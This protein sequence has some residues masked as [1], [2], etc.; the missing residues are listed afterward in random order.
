MP[1]ANLRL[2]AKWTANAGTAY[3]AKHYQENIAAGTYTLAATQASSGTSGTTVTPPLNTYT[4]FTAPATQT[5]TIKGDGSTVLNY[6]YTRNSYQRTFHP[7]NGQSDTVNT[8][9]YGALIILPTVT[10]AGYT[11]GGWYDNGAFTGTPYTATSTMPAASLELYAKWTANAGTAYTVKH[12]RE[13]LA[14]TL[15]SLFETETLYGTSGSPVAP[16][17]RTYEGFAAPAPQ[18]V[19]INGDGST[20][21]RYEYQRMGYDLICHPENGQPGT[22]TDTIRY[23]ATLVLPPVAYVGFTFEGWF[24]NANYTGQPYVP[25]TMPAN[26][27]ELWAKWRI[28]ATIS[29]P[30]TV[31]SELST[32]VDGTVPAPALVHDAVTLA[33]STSA[34]D[35][36]PTGSIVV[37]GTMPD[38]K[39]WVVCN[40]PIPAD[41]A[42]PF[43]VTTTDQVLGTG[44]P[45]NGGVLG[46][47]LYKFEAEY[48]PAEG[49]L[50]YPE[51]S[52]VEQVTVT[53]PVGWSENFDSYGVGS[54]INGQGGWQNMQ[55]FDT[56]PLQ[57][58]NTPSRSG[59]NSLELTPQTHQGDIRI[60]GHPY[61][62]ATSG[63]WEVSFWWYVPYATEH[64][65]FQI[66]NELYARELSCNHEYLTLWDGENGAVASATLIAGQWVP[67][68]YLVDLDSDTYEVW[69]N[70][71]SLY[72]GV[73]PATT[74]TFVV[75][76]LNGTT[77]NGY[78]DDVSV[79]PVTP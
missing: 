4:G 5:V 33:W 6:Y 12:Y 25:T 44:A 9:K 58:S 43:V 10:K 63:R 36:A 13:I 34:G 79:L 30:A 66:D 55:I 15:Y 8:I 17:V 2:Y 14:G 46:Q 32:G 7:N 78:I 75:G 72:A 11:F 45:W 74:I 54:D 68:R 50:F 49:S 21:V 31:S 60:V 76:S 67:V 16:A 23:G 19:S 38:G 51:N 71:D 35:V 24:T 59:G 70:G 42:Q 26:N 48:V 18:T 69:Y 77:S 39:T 73:F 1:A 28:Q 61:P 20:I 53:A 64:A 41:A 22:I 29:L 52:D 3:T 40:E 65:F 57:V 62:Q 56:T 27:V 47:G 37:T